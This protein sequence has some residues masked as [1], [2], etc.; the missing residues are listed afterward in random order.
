MQRPTAKYQMELR[1]SCG[2]MGDRFEGTGGVMGT[3]RKSTESTKPGLWGLTEIEP[4]TKKH[5]GAR[6]QT[7]TY[8]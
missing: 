2:R 6:P 5:A 4:P 8:L 3:T 1:E 7:P